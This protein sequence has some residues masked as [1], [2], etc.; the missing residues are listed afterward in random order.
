MRPLLLSLC[1]YTATISAARF[2][3]GLYLEPNHG[4]VDPTAKFLARHGRHTLFLTDKGAI[5]VLDGKD[6][7]RMTLAGS[8]GASAIT[9]ADLQPARSNYLN[10]DSKAKDVFDVPHYGRVV[11]HDVYPSID[12]AF[13]ANGADLEYDFILKP[14]AD[15]A[16]IQIDFSGAKPAMAPNGDLVLKTASGELRQHKPRVYQTSA[17]RQVEVR[18]QYRIRGSRMAFAIAAYNPSVALIIDPPTT[19]TTYL[20]GSGFD[21]GLGIRTNGAGN[22]YVLGETNSTNFPRTAN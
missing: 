8:K 10:L 1:L 14:V 4:Q 17:G 21:G 20:G 22:A 18:S 16:K 7:I 19:Y 11:L 15:P 2:T 9:G 3:P 5:S 6:V 13:Y 12:L